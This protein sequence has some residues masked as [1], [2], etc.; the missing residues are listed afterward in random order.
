EAACDAF[1]HVAN[2]LETIAVKES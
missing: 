1:E 2:T